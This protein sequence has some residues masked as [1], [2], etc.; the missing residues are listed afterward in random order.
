MDNIKVFAPTGTHFWIG[1]R[2]TRSGSELAPTLKWVNQWPVTHQDNELIPWLTKTGIP[3]MGNGFA[4]TSN[5]LCVGYMNYLPPTSGYA[6]YYDCDN[7][8]FNAICE[9]NNSVRSRLGERIVETIVQT[10]YSSEN[11]RSRLSDAVRSRLGHD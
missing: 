10:E 1:A 11:R 7:M 4:S 5:V 2:A 8:K 9:I 6:Y 3:S